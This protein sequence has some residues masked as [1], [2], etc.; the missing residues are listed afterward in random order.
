MCT[1]YSGEILPISILLY[2]APYPSIQVVLTWYPQGL[3]GTKAAWPQL[4]LE[5]QYST[6][7]CSLESS[8]IV[9]IRRQLWLSVRGTVRVVF[10]LVDHFIAVGTMELTCPSSIPLVNCLGL[11]PSK[12]SLVRIWLSSSLFNL[13]EIQDTNL[14]H[15]LSSTIILSVVIFFPS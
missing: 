4:V 15:M 7:H 1:A 12:T 14:T 3:L 2:H 8:R 13:L 5:P 10:T 9:L 6:I 11:K